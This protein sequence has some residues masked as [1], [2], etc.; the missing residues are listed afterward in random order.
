MY[1]QE[2]LNQNLK[3]ELEVAKFLDFT[4][5]YSKQMSTQKNMRE[6]LLIRRRAQKKSNKIS[7]STNSEMAQIL[8]DLPKFSNKSESVHNTSVAKTIKNL[9]VSDQSE[10]ND[11]KEWRDSRPHISFSKF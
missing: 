10:A 2:I 6:R 8:D 5:Q 3:V 1:S 7:N 11:G 9:K 4:H